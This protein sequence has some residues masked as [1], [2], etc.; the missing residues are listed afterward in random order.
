MGADGLSRSAA[1]LIT[2]LSQTFIDILFIVFTCFVQK[3]KVLKTF[4]VTIFHETSFES[5]LICAAEGQVYGNEVLDQQ[6][7]MP[8]R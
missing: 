6:W 3:S 8:L 2:T 5:S 7:K 4:V 1:Y